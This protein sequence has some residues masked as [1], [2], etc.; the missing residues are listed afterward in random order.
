M[1][2]NF[3]VVLFDFDGTIADTSDGIFKSLKF[4]FKECGY[5]EPDESKLVKMI[6]PSLYDGFREVFGIQKEDATK[7]IAKYRERYNIIGIFECSLYDG[8]EEHLK[9]LKASGV[10]LSAASSKPLPFVERILDYFDLHKYF[11]YVSCTSFD[12]AE[13]TKA[14]V[15]NNGLEALNVSDKSRAVMV[16]DRLYDIEGAKEAGIPCIAVLY[17]FGNM[18]EFL[19]YKADYIVNDVNDIEKVILGE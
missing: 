18:E 10:K 12:A 17:G 9:T 15:I 4:A 5:P 19:E 8:I 6:G 11:D 7:L 14:D 3:D 13:M 2:R 16:G 1:K